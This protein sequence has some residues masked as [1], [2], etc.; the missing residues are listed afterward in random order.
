MGPDE[1]KRFGLASVAEAGTP[2]RIEAAA[3]RIA[4]GSPG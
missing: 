3:E 2:E 4:S 1:L